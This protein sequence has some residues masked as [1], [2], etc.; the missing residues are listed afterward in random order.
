MAFWII[1]IHQKFKL[2][3]AEQIYS[4]FSL[5][6]SCC[7]LHFFSSMNGS[8]TITLAAKDILNCALPDAT[9]SKFAE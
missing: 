6:T 7:H 8:T 9:Q 1:C 4:L 2:F 5:L 3:L